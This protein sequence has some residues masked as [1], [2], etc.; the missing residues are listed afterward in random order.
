[1]ASHP[2]ASAVRRP[3]SASRA[4]GPG[5]ARSPASASPRA[6]VSCGGASQA[7]V[8]CSANSSMPPARTPS[9]GTPDAMASSSEFP[10][11][12]VGEGKA[13]RSALA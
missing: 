3:P 7:L 8:S 12:S 1:M 2:R 9:A 11:V 5:L 4:R 13:K 10:K 6:A